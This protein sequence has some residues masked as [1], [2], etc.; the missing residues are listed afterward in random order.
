MNTI[1][2]RSYACE[3]QKIRNTIAI[4]LCILGACFIPVIMVV[5]Q[6]YAPD[7]LSY[8]ANPEVFW[9]RHY[10]RTWEF[11]SVL[12][13]PFGIILIT[14]MLTQLEFRNTTWK[15]TLLTPQSLSTIFFAKLAVIMTLLFLFY[16][17][18]HAAIIVSGIVPG[19]LHSSIE[20]PKHMPP[21]GKMLADAGAIWLTSLP[22][23]GFHYLLNLRFSNFIIPISIG[24]V[25]IVA[26]IFALQWKH[27]YCVPF[28]YTTF[29][30]LTMSGQEKFKF[31]YSIYQ[32]SWVWFAVFVAIAYFSFLY[33]KYKA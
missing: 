16:I 30:F 27:G 32:L 13:L 5:A 18:F 6:L 24:L 14:S 7:Q 20:V 25:C 22:L 33:R 26:S 1:F 21:M 2:F 9:E 17:A 4:R 29:H 28:S 31:P 10:I 15:Q 11:M 3:W 19:L 12:L 23:V 8:S